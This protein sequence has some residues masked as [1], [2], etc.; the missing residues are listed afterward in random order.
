M[1]LIHQAMKQENYIVKQVENI[2]EKTNHMKI[3]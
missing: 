2:L 3:C 1:K